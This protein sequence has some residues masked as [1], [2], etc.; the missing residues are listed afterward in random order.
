MTCKDRCMRCA[1]GAAAV[2]DAFVRLHEQGLIYK[3]TYMVNWAPKLQTAVSDLEVEYTDEN[4]SLFVFKYPLAGDAEG[5][6]LPVA[7]T[8]P[9]ILK[10]RGTRILLAR[11]S[12]CQ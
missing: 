6:H 7:T 5:K 12:R 8:W 2:A 4:G 11:R 1:S 9:C 10:M 3:G